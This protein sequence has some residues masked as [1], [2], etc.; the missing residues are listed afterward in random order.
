[1]IDA[2]VEVVTLAPVVFEE[3]RAAAYEFSAK[4]IEAEGVQADVDEAM[5]YVAANAK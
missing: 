2:G 1:M 4:Q 3:F 5:A